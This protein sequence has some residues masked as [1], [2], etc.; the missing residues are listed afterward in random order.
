M[1]PLNRLVTTRGHAAF[2]VLWTVAMLVI[3]LGFAGVGGLRFAP[4]LLLLIPFAATRS[5]FRR[6]DQTP[7]PTTSLGALW[8]LNLI[9][10]AAMF[11][12][13]VY[14]YSLALLSYCPSP[15]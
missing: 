6:T 4:W 3:I 1:L 5:A 7:G 13:F 15:K 8:A 14:L 9:T 10:E 2:G 12:V 11:A